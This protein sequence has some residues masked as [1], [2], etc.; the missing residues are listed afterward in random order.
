M[1]LWMVKVMEHEARC[2]VVCVNSGRR[3]C[4]SERA[5]VT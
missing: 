1:V 2:L 3:W 4:M 5:P